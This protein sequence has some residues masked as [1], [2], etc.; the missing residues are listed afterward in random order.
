MGCVFIKVKPRKSSLKLGI[1]A[2]MTPKY[3]GPFDVL[4]DTIG[5]V[6]YKIA[7]PTSIRTHNV[8]HTSSLKKYVHGP[9]HVIDWVVI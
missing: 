2:K 3:Q 7:L 8:F 6:V 5:L 1:C 9:S 4:A